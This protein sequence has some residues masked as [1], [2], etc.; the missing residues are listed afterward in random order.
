[1][2]KGLDYSNDIVLVKYDSLMGLINERQG[3]SHI[4]IRAVKDKEETLTND[5]TEFSDSLKN[6]FWHIVEKIQ[7]DFR[8]D[9]ML[10]HH[11]GFFR[12]ANHFHVH[13][14][15][16]KNDFGQYCTRKNTSSSLSSDDIAKHIEKR[17]RKLMERYCEYK[18]SDYKEIEAKK[19]DNPKKCPSEYKGYRIEIHPY[20]ARINFFNM[21]PYEYSEDDNVLRKQIQNYRQEIVDVM[22]SFAKEYG[23][24]GYRTWQNIKGDLFLINSKYQNKREKIRGFLQVHAPDLYAIHPNPDVWF[25]YWAKPDTHPENTSKIVYDPIACV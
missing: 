5:L 11:F 2:K 12:S 4:I 13:L 23:F 22:V 19:P 15:V 3:R 16:H 8:Y 10:S 6:E 25:K 18:V 20:F 14:L 24:T 9:M 7:Y 21:K 1:M 17:C